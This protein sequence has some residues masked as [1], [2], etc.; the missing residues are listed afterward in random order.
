MSSAPVAAANASTVPA[1]VQQLPRSP[2]LSASAAPQR[3]PVGNSLGAATVAVLG[4]AAELEVKA[5]LDPAAPAAA[6]SLADRKITKYRLP[7]SSP[8]ATHDVWS[9]E[10]ITAI[11][12]EHLTALVKAIISLFKYYVMTWG[13]DAKLVEKLMQRISE[14]NFELDLGLEGDKNW[15]SA[16]NE[17][18]QNRDMIAYL[19]GDKKAKAFTAFLDLIRARMIDTTTGGVK[20]LEMDGFTQEVE[21]LTRIIRNPTHDN[22]KGLA[23]NRQFGDEQAAK[24]VVARALQDGFKL[25]QSAL[26]EM[27][28]RA[29]NH[30]LVYS[31][32]M[33]MMN[34]AKANHTRFPAGAAL[35]AELRESLSMSDEQLLE[36]INERLVD[37]HKVFGQRNTTQLADALRQNIDEAER[38]RIAAEQAARETAAKAEAEAAGAM[39]TGLPPF[40]ACN[41]LSAAPAAAELAPA[42]AAAAGDEAVEVTVTIAEQDTVR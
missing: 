2:S 30:E 24:V 11:T 35:A 15:V 12:T 29:F 10:G 25:M 1:Q 42:P 31:T 14:E 4:Q 26:N 36:A 9:V 6:A 28:V 32:L 27:S 34:D 38:A 8:L 41:V 22:F 18:E 21:I 19:L 3:A 16:L 40:L 33:L 23:V 7:E 13:D 20:E 5:A 39:A 37:L 17:I